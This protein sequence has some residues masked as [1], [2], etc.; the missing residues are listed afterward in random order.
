M[1]GQWL[2]YFENVWGRTCSHWEISKVT[3]KVTTNNAKA[4]HIFDDKLNIIL[5][6]LNQLHASYEEDKKVQERKME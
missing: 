4:V 3:F 1:F 2:L 5:T 6:Y